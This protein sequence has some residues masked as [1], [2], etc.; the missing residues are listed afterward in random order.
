MQK[1]CILERFRD[2]DRSKAYKLPYM[3]VG[4]G[5]G[6][7]DA[8]HGIWTPDQ[9]NPS[10]Y[11]AWPPDCHDQVRFCIYTNT[12]NVNAAEN[13]PHVLQYIFLV[14]FTNTCLTTVTLVDN[15][16]FLCK[17]QQIQSYLTSVT[18]H[19]LLSGH[20]VKYVSERRISHMRCWRSQDP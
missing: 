7:Q 3:N 13:L 12:Q 8:G 10:G 18:S 2:R 5:W 15:S 14:S 17:S 1:W 6:R 9:E 16:P 4:I 19:L 20:D 11:Q